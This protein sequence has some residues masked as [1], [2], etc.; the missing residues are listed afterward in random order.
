[1]ELVSLVIIGAIVSAL[2]QWLKKAFGANTAGVY[3]IVIILSIVASTVYVVY[4]DA[5]WWATLVQ[6]L[7]AS[8]GV[9]NYIIRRFEDEDPT[10]THF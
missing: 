7:S 3:L 4:K 9:Y 6:I 5:S 2:V 8:G 10:E 1:M